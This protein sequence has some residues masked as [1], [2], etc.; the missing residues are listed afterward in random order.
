VRQGAGTGAELP[1]FVGP[2]GGQRVGHLR[3]QRAAEQ[4]R[5]LRRGGEVAA[6]A[7]HALGQQA[8]FGQRVGVVAQAWRVQRHRHEAV[9]ADPAAGVADG[10]LQQLE[11]GAR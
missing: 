9:K 3:G 1:D 4:R 7:V 11:Q 5:D 6:F 10:A 2:G 8:E